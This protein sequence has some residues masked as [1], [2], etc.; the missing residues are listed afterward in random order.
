MSQRDFYT[1]IYRGFAPDWCVCDQAVRRLPDG[2]LG[3]FYMTGGN[4]EPERANFVALCRSADNGASWTKP[5]VVIRAAD[6]AWTMTEVIVNGDEIS[7]FLQSHEGFFEDW[8]VHLIRSRDNGQ[9]WSAPEDFSPLPRRNF[10]RN[11]LK[12]SWGEWLFP[13][14]TYDTRP[15]PLPSPLKDGSHQAA[16]GALITADE[17]KTWTVSAR[18]GS[19]P[20]WAEPNL[21]E[22]PGERI[23]MLIRAD[24]Q[25]HLLRCESTDRGRT[26]S[27]PKPAGIANPGTKFRLFDLGDG[28]IALLHNPN[29]KCGQRNPLALWISADNMQTWPEQR[30]L[31]DFPGQLQYP[32]GFYDPAE[33]AIHFAFDYNRHDL[34]YW[35]AYI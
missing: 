1:L 19:I 23:V 20:G 13:Y 15:D 27:E 11:L 26:W 34:I 18:V 12:T 4:T 25:G 8:R 31:T 21:I 3:A 2:T 10:V 29:P 30:V 14:Q 28:R 22:L 5:Q 7:I 17:M 24:G 32:D 35:R 16:V 6:R 33:K 9:T